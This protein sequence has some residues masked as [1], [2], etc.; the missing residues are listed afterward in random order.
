MAERYDE[1]AAA[2]YAAY[3]PP[4]HR[5]ILDRVLSKDESFNLG[6]DVGCGTGYSAIALADRCAR[7]YGVDPSP[8][9]LT[10]ATANERVIYL[11]GSAEH[12]PL[13][14]RSVDVVTFAGSLFYAD[15]DAASEETRR[16]CERGAIVIVYDFEILLNDVLHRCGIDARTVASDYNHN[17][18]FSGAAGFTELAARSERVN[19]EVTTSELAHVLLSDSSRF[20]QLG[21]T[22]RAA[23]PF[24]AV[25]EA[26][27]SAYDRAT[28]DADIYYSKYR[29][30]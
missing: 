3:R 2:H 24:A 21:K 29:I 12:I 25:S 22:F 28:I 17:V 9:M 10:R 14:D 6:V 26:L 27:Q 16:V 15:S 8:S 30:T 18:N 23:D 11:G 1:V 7:V 4:L 5:I 20:D 13:A 19:L